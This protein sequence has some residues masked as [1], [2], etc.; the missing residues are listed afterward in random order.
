ML[1]LIAGKAQLIDPTS[2]I[3]HG[4]CEEACPVKAITLVF[5]TETRGVDIPAVSA[6]FE[7]NVPGLYLAGEI[8]GMGLIR[9]AIKQGCE[10]VD[11]I[12]ADLERAGTMDS[13][14]LDLLIVGAGPTGIAASLRAR[15][16]GL[17]VRTVEQDSLGGTVTHYPRNKLVMTG[18]ARLPLYGDLDFREIGKEK[19]LE[20]WQDVVE[21]T[22]IEI[23]C[24]E[25]VLDIS[26]VREGFA[27]KTSNRRYEAK[28]VLLAIGRRGTPRRL[29]VP[30]EELEKVVYRLCDPDQYRGRR[31][32]VVGGGDSALEAAAELAQQD[33][34]HVTLSYRGEAFSRARRQNR[35]AVQRAAEEGRI[36]MF[37]NSTIRMI[38]EAVVVLD[39]GGRETVILNDD[40]IVCAGGVLPTGFLQ[41]IGVEF[42]RKFG[43]R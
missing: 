26:P 32:L 15:E 33:A 3:G 40:V 4:A 25:A 13:E 18:A 22:G 29:D 36:D 30:G 12:A 5:G 43:T 23:D 6:E 10:A 9:N 24:R 20:I 2:C 42:E 34:T 1:G 28:R 17:S 11:A 27:V 19:L 39:Q 8:G 16:L 31:V 7:T 35:E 37:L 14:A 41:G 21:K 38:G